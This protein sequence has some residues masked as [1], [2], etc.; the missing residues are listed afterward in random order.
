MNYLIFVSMRTKKVYQYTW[1]Q[2][3]QELGGTYINIKWGDLSILTE[4]MKYEQIFKKVSG[5]VIWVVGFIPGEMNSKCT[6][7]SKTKEAGVA[8][9]SW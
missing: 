8:G 5:L 7:C 2:E 3:C 1:D 6:I 4:M 9:I